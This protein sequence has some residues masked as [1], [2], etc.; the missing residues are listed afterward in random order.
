MGVV[1]GAQEQGE[2][3]GQRVESGIEVRGPRGRGAE[4]RGVEHRLGAGSGDQ[5]GQFAAGEP[6]GDQVSGAA[7]V[8]SACLRSAS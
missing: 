3:G 2:P 1:A 6:R 5:P 7:P 4:Q 8:A